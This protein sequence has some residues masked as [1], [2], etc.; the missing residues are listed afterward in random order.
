M[1]QAIASL[2]LI[3]FFAC[4]GGDGGDGDG[5]GGG[6]G[7]GDGDGDGEG[8]GDGDGDE[9]R[10]QLT[11]LVTEQRVT[12]PAFQNGSVGA[13]MLPFLSPAQ[14]ACVEASSVVF[15][16]GGCAVIEFAPLDC[17]PACGADQ[18]CGFDDS[19]DCTPVCLEV[20]TMECDDGSYCQLDGGGEMSCQPSEPYEA[21]GA[22]AIDGV[23][24]PV[25]LDQPTY[26]FAPFADVVYAGGSVIATA[27][28]AAN[29]GITGFSIAG[30][31]PPDPIASPPLAELTGADF[32]DDLSVSWPAGADDIEID[33]FAGTT[34]I[35]CRAADD[36]QFVVPAS[37]LSRIDPSATAARID[38]RRVRDFVSSEPTG[39]GTYLGLELPEAAEVILRL[40]RLETATTLL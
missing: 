7:D 17:A 32:T 21:A 9:R 4:G 5:D 14:T 15:E 25:V 40:V 2:A 16:D 8:D 19:G 13:F 24:E 18:V 12:D 31:P 10:A 22:I 3:P 39:F 29:A 35:S 20:C 1:R 38:L 26:G 6:D 23:T 28:G 34:R 11:I 37:V 27:A 33:I 30:D 36:G